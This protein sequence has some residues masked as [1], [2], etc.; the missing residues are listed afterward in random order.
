MSANGFGLGI[1]KGMAVTLRH[2]FRRPFTVQYP[3]ERLPL[4]PR[5][6]GYEFTWVEERCTV[7][8]TCAKACPHGVITI[9]STPIG[10]NRYRAEKFDIDRGLCMYC[11]LCVEACP[12]EALYMGSKFELGEY[13][14]SDLVANRDSLSSAPKKPSSYFH[15]H[16]EKEPLEEVRGAHQLTGGHR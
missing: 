9:V 2:L 1:L 14:R 13:R 6:R 8:A 4:P 15:P 16:L 11:G 10:G 5:F 7:C 12:F 3:E